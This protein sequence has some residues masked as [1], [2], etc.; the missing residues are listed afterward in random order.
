MEVPV[1]GCV[2]QNLFITKALGDSNATKIG[3]FVAQWTTQ[4]LKFFDVCVPG[5]SDVDKFREYKNKYSIMGNDG[6]YAK[7][8]PLLPI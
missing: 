1:L 2:F 5:N 4:T 8:F 3:N 7:V 6:S